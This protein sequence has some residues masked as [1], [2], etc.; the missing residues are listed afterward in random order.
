MLLIK[1]PPISTIANHFDGPEIVDICVAYSNGVALVALT[2]ELDVSNSEWLFECLHDAID[3]GASE[4]VV[5]VEHLSFMDSTG[6]AVIMGAY[7]RMKA[8]GGTLSVLAPTP[9]VV[10]LF[11]LFEDAPH[12]IIQQS[13]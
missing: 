7:K 11:H 12:L 9:I 13:R 5:N 10:R 3:A 2:G 4:V 1:E 6:L 8:T